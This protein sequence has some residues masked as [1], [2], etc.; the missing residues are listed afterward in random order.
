[1]AISGTT[2]GY[3]INGS[4]AGVYLFEALPPG[5]YTI[6][7]GNFGLPSCAL[8]APLGWLGHE[9]TSSCDSRPNLT[10]RTATVYLHKAQQLSGIDF[11]E[12]P[13][14]GVSGRIWVDATPASQDAYVVVT[15]GGRACWRANV[16]H[17]VTPLQIS[18]AVFTADLK[19]TADAGCEGAD[20]D[21]QVDGRALGANV[22]WNQ[23]WVDQ[24][25]AVETGR[26]GRRGDLMVPPFMGLAGRI[27]E[28]QQVA[29]EY[30]NPDLVEDGSVVRI[31]VGSTSCARATTLTLEGRYG[32]MNL[33]GVI[34]PSADLKD[35][36]GTEDAPVTLCVGSARAKQ[37]WG[38]PLKWK[39]GEIVYPI[40]EV[41]EEACPL[42]AVLPITGGSPATRGDWRLPAIGV[43]LL[44]LGVLAL[45]SIARRGGAG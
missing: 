3:T 39:P 38:E 32:K 41:T 8:A 4:A 33:F 6:Y 27:V 14:T 45:S 26:L 29:S 36:C 7:A 13:P 37:F 23:L 21:V 9:P 43:A 30:P 24:L 16:S 1:M 25:W 12:V 42:A 44:T 18:T 10:V 20:I 35:G 5:R 11:P 19:P 31:I 28:P 15:V 2:F 22:S 17:E 34:V 40:F